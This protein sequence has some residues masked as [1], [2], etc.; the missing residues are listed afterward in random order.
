MKIYVW[1][2][3]APAEGRRVCVYDGVTT[4]IQEAVNNYWIIS[5]DGNDGW[6]DEHDVL[7]GHTRTLRFFRNPELQPYLDRAKELTKWQSINDLRP[8]RV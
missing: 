7:S 3:N 8:E 5:L 2:Y 6:V 1:G 4:S